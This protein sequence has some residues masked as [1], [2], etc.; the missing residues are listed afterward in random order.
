MLALIPRDDAVDLLFERNAWI[1]LKAPVLLYLAWGFFLP[2]AWKI[3]LLMLASV[4]C[5]FFSPCVV[6]QA[7][8]ES[9]LWFMLVT[10]MAMM[11]LVAWYTVYAFAFL[12]TAG[13]LNRVVGVLGVLAS[14]IAPILGVL[15]IAAVGTWLSV[16]F[17]EFWRFFDSW[18]PFQAWRV[19]R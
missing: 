12:Q 17:E 6:G 10:Q 4:A 18:T 3:V 16:P 15:A 2:A 13:A 14:P 19:I 11:T 7:V 9:H 5:T 8:T 1:W